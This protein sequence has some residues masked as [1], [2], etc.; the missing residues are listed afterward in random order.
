MNMFDFTS[1][2]A[3][4][5]ARELVIERQFA[6]SRTVMFQMFTQPEHL[7]HW[8][9]PGPYTLP[10]CTLDLRPGGIWHYCIRSP[11]G[12]DFW[13]R[14]VYSEVIPPEKLVYTSTSADEYANPTEGI[15]EHLTTVT[16]TQDD[17]FTLVRAQISFAS[18]QALQAAV[19]MRMWEGMNMTW[20]SLIRYVQERHMP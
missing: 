3:P 17:N 20:D 13:A 1:L 10:I 16:F 12:Q 6:A 19:A 18:A 7:K 4:A 11:Q 5:Q 2:H 15:P 14:S 8:W 9:A